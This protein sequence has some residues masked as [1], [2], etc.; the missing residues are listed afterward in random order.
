MQCLHRDAEELDI[1]VC[2]CSRQDAEDTFSTPSLSTMK[3]VGLIALSVIA[4]VVVGAVMNYGLGVDPESM[5]Y[6][7][8]FAVSVVVLGAGLFVGFRR[9]PKSLMFTA[10]TALASVAVV[11][12]VDLVVAVVHSCAKG[13]CI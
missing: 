4:Y 9:A 11:L 2:D 1:D 12:G 13:V 10:V 6:V 8:P 5:W 7:A 3:L